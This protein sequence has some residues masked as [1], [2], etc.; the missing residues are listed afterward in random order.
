MNYGRVYSEE[1]RKA[2][3][4]RMKG[5]NNPNY[6]KHFSEEHRKKISESN[7]GKHGQT[8]SDN[9]NSKQI[10]QYTKDGSLI[11]IW[12]GIQETSRKTK[13]SASHISACCLGKRKSA[14]GFMWKHVTDEPILKHIEPY[15]SK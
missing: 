9:A 11:K 10:A 2:M 3:S 1:E 5:K 13:I 15:K 12:T 8:G 4:D 6:G 14:G 7:K